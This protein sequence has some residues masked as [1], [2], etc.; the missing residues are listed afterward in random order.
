MYQTV[1]IKTFFSSLRILINWICGYINVIIKHRKKR[2][3]NSDLPKM[4][5]IYL[6]LKI[7]CHSGLFTG[8]V[9]I[10]IRHVCSNI[11]Q[12]TCWIVINNIGSYI[13]ALMKWLWEMEIG[14]LVWNLIII[15]LEFYPK[16]NVLQI[17]MF[18]NYKSYSY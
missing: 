15:S 14:R 7:N 2:F 17:Y 12:T 11:P 8:D 13:I 4:F 16:Q 6:Y 3:R 1:L 9:K 10:P 18:N 5:C